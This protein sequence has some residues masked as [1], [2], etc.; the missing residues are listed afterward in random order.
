MLI[1]LSQLGM[2]TIADLAGADAGTLRAELGEISRLVD[3]EAWILRAR[4]ASG[5]GVEVG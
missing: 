1:R 5:T 4:Q 3:V 2:H